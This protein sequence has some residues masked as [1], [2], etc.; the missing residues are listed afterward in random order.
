MPCDPLSGGAEPNP[1]ILSRDE[2][3]QKLSVSSGPVRGGH[4]EPD[5]SFVPRSSKKPHGRC[6]LEGSPPSTWASPSRAAVG[7]SSLPPLA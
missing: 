7:D 2:G 1:L 4:G 5:S 3:G 6:P